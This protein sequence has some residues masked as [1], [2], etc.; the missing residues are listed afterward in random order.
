MKV[1]SRLAGVMLLG[2]GL[3]LSSTMTGG[4][5]APM[6]PRRPELEYLEA[7]NRAA[8]PADPQLLFILMAQYAN[9]NLHGQGAEF[10]AARLREFTPRLTDSQKALYLSAIGMLRAGHSAQVPFWRRLGWV[11]ETIGMFEE[12]KRLSG[13]KVYV[14]RWM[15]GVVRAQ[16]PSF[17]GQAAPAHEDL[18]WCLAHADQAPHAGW[19][20][21]VYYQLASLDRRAGD[22]RS[23]QANLRRSGYVAFDKP[24]TFTTPF[25][26]N[27][28]T[29]HTIWP[30]RI[31]DVLPGKIYALS[32]F[33]FTEYYFIVTEDRRELVAID[34]A[35]GRIRR[36]RRTRRCGLMRLTCPSLPPCW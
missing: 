5:A 20:R 13:E 11:K 31:V 18:T 3:L 6:V 1:P 19:S 29:G 35:R 4:A 14:V 21:E 30:R 16:L 12:A 23:A 34:A 9:A 36:R 27:V 7:V 24:V 33:E 32:G 10:F 28:A 22:P 8:P 2:V 17:F 26:E 15:S 25:S